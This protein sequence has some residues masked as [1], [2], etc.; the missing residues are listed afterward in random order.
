MGARAPD[1]GWG[2]GHA[3]AGRAGPLSPCPCRSTATGVSAKPDAAAGV[4][5]HV[6]A[7]PGAQA[8]CFAVTTTPRHKRRTDGSRI[9]SWG[10]LT[11]TPARPPWDPP[12]GL[13]QTTF[14]VRVSAHPSGR[15][16]RRLAT[17]PLVPSLLRGRGHE[18]HPLGVPF[19]GLSPPPFQQRLD[20]IEGFTLT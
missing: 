19:L 6:G 5:A 13:P 16:G 18:E 10:V 11:P 3:A 12:R 15:Q 14:Q 8:L 9:R 20:L 1:T 2:H 4:L 7:E 17:V